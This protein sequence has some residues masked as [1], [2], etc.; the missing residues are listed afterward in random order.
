MLLTG[1]PGGAGDSG[2]TD[3]G[4]ETGDPVDLEAPVLLEPL[5][6]ELV[7]PVTRTADL[8]LGVAAITPGVTRVMIDG[9]NVGPLHADNRIGTLTSST[10]TLR[11]AG[12]MVPG[13]HQLK[14]TTPGALDDNG[15]PLESR[16]VT[17]RLNG[18]LTPVPVASVGD[19]AALTADAIISGGY[20]TDGVLIAVDQEAVPPGGHRVSRRRRR[21]GSRHAGRLRADRVRTRRRSPSRAERMHV[22]GDGLE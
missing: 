16:E 3:A 9:V 21:L 19:T 1:C 17:I 22:R 4:T 2:D 15:D 14:L 6:E 12:A 8:E 13:T 11:L 7:L 10:L 20:D 18:V 5:D